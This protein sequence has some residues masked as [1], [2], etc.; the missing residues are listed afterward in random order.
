MPLNDFFYR[1]VLNLDD[2]VFDHNAQKLSFT[3][4]I[5]YEMLSSQHFPVYLGHTL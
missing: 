4:S 1:G 5:S 2:Y 3:S